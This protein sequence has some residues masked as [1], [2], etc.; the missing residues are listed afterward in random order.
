MQIPIAQTLG[1]DDTG[2]AEDKALADVLERMNEELL[3]ARGPLDQGLRQTETASETKSR[4]L[5]T[6]SHEIRSPLHV[7]L[8]MN[9]LLL[10]SGLGP[11]QREYVQLSQEAGQ[12]LMAL[13]NDILDFSKLEAGSLRLGSEWFNLQQT[14]EQVT[15][16]FY[17]QADGKRIEL[18]TL[19]APGTPRRCLGDASRVRQILINLVSNAIKFTGQGGVILRV[20]PAGPEGGI[21]I[22]VEDSGIGIPPE[23]QERIF[24]EFV[25]LDTGDNRLF[26]GSGLGLSIVRRLTRLM[27]G[28]IRVESEPGKGSRFRVSLPLRGEDPLDAWRTAGGRPGGV[29]CLNLSNPVLSRG[30]REQIELMGIKVCDFGT[31][32]DYQ[33]M[34]EGEY[35]MLVD[36]AKD[37]LSA[38]E[39]RDMTAALPQ[40]ERW[41]IVTLLNMHGGGSV[42]RTRQAGFDAV[43]RKP[44]RLGSLI[45]YLTEPPAPLEAANDPAGLGAGSDAPL[46][47]LGKQILLVEDTRSIQIA[48][49]ALLT[50][51]GYEVA[52]AENGREAL[53]AAATRRFDVILMDLAMPVMGGLEATQILRAQSGPNRRTP[54]IA[55]TAYAFPEDRER[56]LAAGMS[57]YLSKPLDVELFN[58]CLGLWTNRTG[59]A[60]VS[61]GSETESPELLDRRKL[62]Q[63]ARDISWGTLAGILPVY[64]DETDQR[65]PRMRKAF[66]AGDWKALGNE[67]HAFKSSSASFG[68]ASLQARAREIESAAKANDGAALASAME[69]LEA[70]AEASSATLT[71]FMAEKT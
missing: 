70:L 65:I 27:G 19:I 1:Q 26:G 23:Q 32:P 38:D 45:R 20:S 60:P 10:E 33:G 59:T 12:I 67:A 41:R 68:L 15:E 43:I 31:L 54:I 11:E 49:Q 34:T 17:S 2:G 39:Y 50:R 4:F 21:A 30:F 7:I 57:D 47:G 46:P 14:L 28:D 42:A 55:L 62:E 13:I 63:M 36:H 9:A 24:G 44:Y 66:T 58:Q 22:E 53:D 16:L 61:A 18:M 48:T 51:K 40:P 56:C 71:A 8:T 35:V 5:A 69:G 37:G 29:V 25:Q 3:R 52:L 64:L 6:M